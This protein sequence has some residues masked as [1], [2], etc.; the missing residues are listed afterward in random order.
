MPRTSYL[1]PPT[2]YLQP[3]ALP[4]LSV[5]LAL[6]LGA[7]IIAAT[8]GDVSLAYRGLWEGSLGSPKAVSETLVAATPYIFAGLGIA[9]AFRAR[10]FN[11]GAEGQIAAGALGSV[12]VGYSVH[13]LPWPLHLLLA[14]AAGCLAGALW[15]GIPGI[16]KARTGAH[17]VI[18]TIM[19]NYIA[20]QA[21]SF[22]LSGPMRDPNPAIAVA[23]TPLVLESA[24]LPVLLEPFRAGWGLVLALAAAGGA[25]WLL[26]RTTIGFE[27]RT[28][29]G[30][31]MR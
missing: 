14:L 25:W 27:V 7:L 6:S 30:G 24:R 28:V 19:L 4:L 1:V 23:Q 13:G 2:S 22:L 15:G 5:F 3:L 20:I 17:E 18:T 16:L 31:A 29:T 21:T 26:F 8:G 9:F 10:L 11:V 12:W